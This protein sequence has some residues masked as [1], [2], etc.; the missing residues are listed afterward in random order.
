MRL[1]GPRVQLPPGLLPSND[2]TPRYGK[3]RQESV[4]ICSS[5]YWPS[6]AH[7]VGR[8]SES[9]WAHSVQESTLHREVCN[10]DQQDEYF[11]T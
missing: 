4:Q 10:I 6:D 2:V 1:F 8:E 9:K 7:P 3:S 5:R 11:S